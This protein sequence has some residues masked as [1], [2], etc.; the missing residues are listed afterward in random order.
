MM[1]LKQLLAKFGFAKT[2]FEKLTFAALGAGSSVAPLFFIKNPKY[3]K[4]GQNFSS[5]HNLRLEAWDSYAG[6][7]YSPQLSIGDNV[8]FNSDVH[9]GCIDKVQI[10]NNVLLASRIFISDH[11]HGEI[12]TE[13]LK[14]PPIARQ[15][16]SKGPVIIEDNVWI[17]EGVSILHGVTIGKNAII[18]AN[19]VVTKSIPPNCVA[20]GIPC[21]VLKA[22]Q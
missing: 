17:G 4:I 5:L 14:L 7:N 22:L 21:K 6:T 19:A 13:A 8:C 20:G 18:G 11:S 12:N 16:F 10:G 9:I 1:L 3:M 2:S 15:L